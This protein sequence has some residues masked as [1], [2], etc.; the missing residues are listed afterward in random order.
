MSARPGPRGGYHAQWYPY[1]DLRIPYKRLE[2]G[3]LTLRY[4]HHRSSV[5]KH[6]INGF[7][8]LMPRFAKLPTKQ[9]KGN[10]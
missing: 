10:A 5:G 7:G 2:F 8:N 3:P 6:V 4:L 1:R 9:I